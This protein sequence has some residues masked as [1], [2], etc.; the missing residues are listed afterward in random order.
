MEYGQHASNPRTHPK[1]ALRPDYFWNADQPEVIRLNQAK[2]LIF[3]EDL[4]S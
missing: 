1:T 4:Q 2:M 3:I